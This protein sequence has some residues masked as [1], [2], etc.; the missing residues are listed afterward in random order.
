MNP[1]LMIALVLGLVCFIGLV[2]IR[3]AQAQAPNPPYLREMPSEQ[4]ILRDVKGAD[5]LDTAARQS[6]AFA[7][8]ST[9]IYDLALVDHRD[10]NHVLP[11]ERKIADY[12]DAASERAWEQVTTAVGRD[13]PRLA[14]LNGY[15]TDPNFKAELLEQFFSPNFRA[16]C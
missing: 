3:H 10:R 2:H 8:L 13:R 11:D 9:I 16:L 7:Q 14:K 15:R 1:R 12:Y 6:G 5:P 4:R